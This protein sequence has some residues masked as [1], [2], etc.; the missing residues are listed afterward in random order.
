M[1]GSG[2]G[3]EFAGVELFVQVGDAYVS[4][5]VQA[6][7]D[8]HQQTV[9]GQLASAAAG[10]I[11]DWPAFRLDR[12]WCEVSVFSDQLK[13]PIVSRSHPIRR[14]AHAIRFCGYGAH[15]STDTNR[16]IRQAYQSI[17]TGE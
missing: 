5:P 3:F 14:L 10:M 15:I 9:I 8:S 17:G 11:R 4:D 6:T 12:P 7:V 2:V 13:D 16:F 1:T